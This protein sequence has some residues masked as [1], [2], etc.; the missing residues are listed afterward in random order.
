MSRPR[1]YKIWTDHKNL[2][3]LLDPSTTG[4]KVTKSTMDRLARWAW[5][6]QGVCYRIR[7]LKGSMNI[8]ADTLSRWGAQGSCPPIN[9]I[10]K[11]A[12][13]NI[14]V[15]RPPLMQVAAHTTRAQPSRSQKKSKRFWRSKMSPPTYMNFPSHESG[16]I[17][18]PCDCHRSSY[19]IKKTE[20]Y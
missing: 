19:P 15:S 5:S 2:R 8:I 11:L 18:K 9:E 16:Q 10:A 1:L 3:Y 13:A 12:R 6:I 7:V 4:I 14:T 20:C 17:Y